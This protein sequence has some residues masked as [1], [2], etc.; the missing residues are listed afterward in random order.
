MTGEELAYTWPNAPKDK[1]P[2]RLYIDY[3]INQDQDAALAN[4]GW[5]VCDVRTLPNKTDA[6][7]AEGLKAVLEGIR[8]GSITPDKDKLRWAELEAKVYGLLTGKDKLADKTPKIN[9][10]VLE[11][12]LDFGKKKAKMR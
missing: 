1:E 11:N 2:K 6:D 10:E 8:V 5:V 3:S 7:R 9:E 4:R 12:L